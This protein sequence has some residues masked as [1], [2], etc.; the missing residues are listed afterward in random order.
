MKNMKIWARMA[1]GIG[2]ILLLIVLNG[3]MSI[4]TLTNIDT[5]VSDI[6]AQYIPLVD[7][8]SRFQ[9]RLKDVPANMNLY[10]LTGNPERWKETEQALVD[11]GKILDDLQKTVY[12]DTLI[13]NTLAD[14]AKNAFSSFEKVLRE[15]HEA[16]ETFMKH[17]A[18]MIATGGIANELADKLKY[19]EL[20]LL[21][22]ALARNDI[23]EAKE[24]M[25]RIRGVDTTS[26][27]LLNTRIRM[28]RSLAV[29][30]RTFSKDNVTVL[31]PKLL[32]SV[33]YLERITRVESLKPVV[34][35]LRQ[36]LI[37]FRDAQAETLKQWDRTDELAI[38]RA[39]TR[40]AALA[41]AADIADLAAKLQTNIVS[42]VVE[43]S[44]T[45]VTMTAI[46]CV[47]LIVLG[48]VI[49][50]V[51]TSSITGPLA[52][53]LHF[54]ESVA[55]GDL[56]RRLRLERK[57]EI[58]NLSQSLDTMV[59]ALNEKI[60]EANKKSEEAAQKETEA[61]QAMRSAEAAGSEA[62]AKTESMLTAA[63]RLEEVADIVSSASSEL[64]AQIEQSER[65]ASEQASRVTETATAMEEMNS[66][67]IEVAKNA[68]IASEVSA[69][70]KEKAESGA[71]IVQKAV[72]SIRQVQQESM[73]LKEDMGRLGEHA[74]SITQI[75]SV[76][77]DIAD[78]T[79]LLALNAAIEAARAGE[80][81]RGFAVV[82]DEVRKLAE[83][84]MASTTDV[85]NA[86]KAIQDSAD[87]SMTQVDKAVKTI[88]EA[89]GFANQS[90]DAL[91]EIVRMADNTADQVRAIATASEQQS[92]TSEQ[93]SRS[94]T[95]VNSIATETARAM[96]E[97]ARAVS[98]LAGQAHV[99][100]SLI[101][102]MKKG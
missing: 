86:I 23:G 60:A 59:D 12:A 62:K 89:T 61:T 27:I 83:K 17:R 55:K 50:F 70:T 40:L 13:E 90:G 47:V 14:K 48:V 51:M 100:T 68:G 41:A 19:D 57:D 66:T 21:G 98:D 16:N 64:S 78:Q 10:L 84:T 72:Q 32:A 6:S 26:S 99:L 38:Q 67:V 34:R 101:D 44:S 102:N 11:S 75:M 52:L 36:Q 15:A 28:L 49:G 56:S 96:E 92:A 18:T 22:E 80:A 94:I 76:I 88:E 85:G 7:L 9:T 46:V 39:N 77:S 42:Q 5:Q 35:D 4:K 24:L 53:A 81:G 91:S 25:L 93:I 3:G 87:K 73:A 71:H 54:A 63:N 45:S 37:N 97:A 69:R 29:Q 43:D 82:A 74:R 1:L 79:N 65:G 33:E 30:D 2:V 8:S 58:G 20:A 31:F 95:Q